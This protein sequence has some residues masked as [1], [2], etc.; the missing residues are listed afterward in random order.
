[1]EE[2]LKW[3]KNVVS[4]NFVN[5]KNLKENKL[6]AQANLEA[7]LVFIHFDKPLLVL[8]SLKR[9]WKANS[10]EFDTKLMTLRV[11]IYCNLCFILVEKVLSQNETPEITKEVLKEFIS[12]T[13]G[14][15][16]SNAYHE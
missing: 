13:L 4:A 9:L 14:G 2:A 3:S 6:Y 10:L 12:E 15:K 1:M 11:L 8:K 7:V 16:T 5:K